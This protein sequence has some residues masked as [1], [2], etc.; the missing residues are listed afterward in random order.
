MAFAISDST[1]SDVDLKSSRTA[2]EDY[3]NMD[4]LTTKNNSG[5]VEQAEIVN[6]YI[7]ASKAVMDKYGIRQQIIT[8]N[9]K[10]DPKVTALRILNDNSIPKEDLTIE[11]LGDTMYKVGYGVHVILPF[12][13]N[14]NDC[15]MYIK[16]VNNEWKDNGSFI[17]SLT[18][19]P[20]RIMDEQEW[21]DLD[22]TDS[23]SSA[24]GGATAKKIIAL[25]M[26]QIGKPYKWGSIGTDT[27]DCSG[28][29][30]YCYNQFQNELIDGK[31]IGRTTYEQVKDGKEVSKDSSAWEVGDLIFPEAGH[32]TAYIGDGK[33]IQA[34]HTGDVV[35]ISV[36][37]ST[38]SSVYAVR[39]VIPEDTTAYSTGDLGQIP[40]DY[41]DA[42][43]YVEGNVTT[44]IGNMNGY[45]FKNN[46]ITDSKNAGIDPYIT[47]S[48]I[49]IES[50]GNPKC[51]T[52]GHNGLM[53]VDSG[54]FDI[55]ANIVKGLDMY[56][57][58]QQAV[59]SSQV[60]V[61]LSAYNSGQGMVIPASQKAGLDLTTC[62][63][64]Q[65]GDA[66]YDFNGSTESKYYASKVLKAYSILKG[67]NA[68]N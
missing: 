21:T 58:K 47:A 3:L 61:I 22:E 10:Q 59:K 20:S 35:K 18:L 31:P 28:L 40:N 49:A 63:V 43:T 27:F 4:N 66:L 33:V 37:N 13:P 54:S 44:F 39:R 32:V 53:Q 57:E 17:S 34:P 56:K 67:K 26:Q 62:T 24:S 12:L 42:L 36:Y 38:W 52:S 11:V 41:S 55:D 51:S 65:L 2:V 50:E 60:H 14:Y 7:Q 48:I 25:L 16:E 30:Y 64:K 29:T 5:Q 68:L 8:Q 23:T 15:F 1:N 6:N 45:G 46:I 19:T 9:T